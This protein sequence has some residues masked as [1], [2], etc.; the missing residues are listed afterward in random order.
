[1]VGEKEIKNKWFIALKPNKGDIFDT[2][3][4]Y[5]LPSPN[6]RYYADPFIFKK[7]DINYLFFED[8]DYKKGVISYC[9]ISKDL[10]LSSP[11]VILDRPYH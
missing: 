6:G 11:E 10:E 3:N 7:D 4:L 8:T 9:T 5:E 1:M 2:N